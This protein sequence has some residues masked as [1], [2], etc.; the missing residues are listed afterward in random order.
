MR[1]NFTSGNGIDRTLPDADADADADADDQQLLGDG[2]HDRGQALEP[3]LGRRR[4]RKFR[5]RI[6]HRF[7][8]QRAPENAQPRGQGGFPLQPQEESIGKSSPNAYTV[9]RL[10]V[11]PFPEIPNSSKRI[12]VPFIEIFL[13][14]AVFASPKRHFDPI[15]RIL[16]WRLCDW[17]FQQNC[18]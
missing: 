17:P 7:G 6:R 5:I 15:H 13:I 9:I 18:T 10:V 11:S 1:E 4:T 3:R 2:D 12:L 14:T 8:E 16:L